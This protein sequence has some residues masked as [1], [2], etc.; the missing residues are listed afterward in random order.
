MQKVE[1][2]TSAEGQTPANKPMSR[3]FN[4][5]AADGSYLGQFRVSDQIP[6]HIQEALT[7]EAVRTAINAATIKA[8]VKKDP[9]FN[10]FAIT[11]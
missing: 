1:T 4:C 9:N 8:S 7:E 6:A 11:A 10:P 5:Y 3:A 2:P